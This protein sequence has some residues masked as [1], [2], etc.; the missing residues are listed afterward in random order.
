MDPF[1]RKIVGW[2]M[3]DHMRT[4]LAPSALAMA[5]QRQRPVA[6]LIHRSDRG[7]QYASHDYRNALAADRRR[8]LELT[9]KGQPLA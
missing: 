2:A 9:N 5:I 1:S 3:H 7:V 6:S 4:E 8:A